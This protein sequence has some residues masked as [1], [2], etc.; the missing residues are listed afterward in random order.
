MTFEIIKK[1]Y[2]RKLWNKQMVKTAVIK[3]VITK[4]QYLEITGEEYIE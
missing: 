3:G 4:V 2:D 1:N